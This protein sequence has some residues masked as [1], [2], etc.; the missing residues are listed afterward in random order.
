MFTQPQHCSTGDD[1]EVVDADRAGLVPR[2]GQ[3]F[4]YAPLLRSG[5]VSLNLEKF[6]DI[7]SHFFFSLAKI[8]IILRGCT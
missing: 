4:L 6:N 5:I 2:A 3:G 8:P 7:S 1:D